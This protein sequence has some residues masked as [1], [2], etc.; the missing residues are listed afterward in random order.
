[1][2]EYAP[3]VFIAFAVMAFVI[4]PVVTW[5]A[6]RRAGYS[7]GSAAWGVAKAPIVM[8]GLLL[9]I[10]LMLQGP[11]GRNE[12]LLLLAYMAATVAP[13]LFFLRAYLARD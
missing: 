1:M 4:V 11:R 10:A 7:R 12:E 2:M 3:V 8:C 9:A 6:L 13:I 5:V